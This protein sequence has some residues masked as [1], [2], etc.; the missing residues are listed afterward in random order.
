M[1]ELSFRRAR[2]A[3]IP[4]ILDLVTAAYRGDDSRQGWTTEA[5]L[6]DGQRVTAD[7]LTSDIMRDEQPREDSAILLG[8]TNGVLVGCAH[9][10]RDA[11]GTGYFGMFAVRPNGQGAGLGKAILA[12]AERRAA[13]EWSVTTMRMTVINLR[14]ELISFYERRGYRR[15]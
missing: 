5:D 10:A 14:G 8:E 13:D 2:L 4:A 1:V 12:E 7:V 9:I 6:L 15:T 11:D 3:D